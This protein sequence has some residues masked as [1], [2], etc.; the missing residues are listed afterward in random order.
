MFPHAV[1]QDWSSPTIVLIHRVTT[2]GTLTGNCIAAQIAHTSSCFRKR[3]NYT[4]TYFSILVRQWLIPS[5]MKKRQRYEISLSPSPMSYS[6]VMMRSKFIS[7][8]PRTTGRQRHS[9][10]GDSVCLIS[11]AFYKLI[12][13]RAKLILLRPSSA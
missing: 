7:S 8:A 11:L 3:R 2:H 9:F 6:R 10:V 13:H 5:I 12:D 4:P 1:G